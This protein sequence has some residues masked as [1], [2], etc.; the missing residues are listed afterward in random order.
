MA[1]KVPG[2][3]VGRTCL[4]MLLLIH[5]PPQTAA[6]ASNERDFCCVLVLC[7]FFSVF[8]PFMKYVS[9]VLGWQA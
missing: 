9:R 2:R 8:L 4:H 1:D 6:S 3:L 7:P 5:V